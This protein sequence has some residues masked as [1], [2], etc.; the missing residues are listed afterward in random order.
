MGEN[1]T[2]LIPLYPLHASCPTIG[3]HSLSWPSH[4]RSLLL[5]A[6]HC[7]AHLYDVHL[8]IRSAHLS[9]GRLP[10]AF[11]TI[12]HPR[13]TSLL[14]SPSFVVPSPHVAISTLIQTALLLLRFLHTSQTSNANSSNSRSIV[15]QFHILDY[16]TYYMRVICQQLPFHSSRLHQLL[17]PIGC[18][19]K[20][21]ILLLACASSIL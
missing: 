13:I 10:S 17:P 9:T 11:L 8:S 3:S 4:L 14:H 6:P 12:V 5:I 2:Q 15:H 20:L 16:F 7:L 21:A 19:C 1:G 18:P